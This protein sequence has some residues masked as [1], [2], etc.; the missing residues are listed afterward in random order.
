MN[1]PR[2]VGADDLQLGPSSATPDLAVVNSQRARS[3]L[4]SR[5][6]LESAVE[7]IAER[8]YERTT[9]VAIGER[10]GYSRGLVTDRFGSKE[11]L[12]WHLLEHHFVKWTEDSLYPDLAGL[13]AA[14]ALNR[15]IE[16]T[17][18]NIRLAPTRIRAVYSILFESLVLVPGVR[19]RVA[20]MHREHRASTAAMITNGIA[21]GDVPSTVD[22]EAMADAWVATFRG[23]A[24]Q[25]LL[26]P[27]T[28]QIDRALREMST[29]FT[30]MLTAGHHGGT[31]AESS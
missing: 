9:L 5:R 19:E 20:M 6:L 22:P 18:D 23:V 21:N 29:L 16:R 10:A 7:L 17:R 1:A 30:P 15:A 31:E 3:E 2:P 12:L 11:K 14:A 25:W 13:P 4:S 8:G 24:Y 26:D 27:E 28:F